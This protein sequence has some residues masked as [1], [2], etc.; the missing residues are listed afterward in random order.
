MENNTTAYSL[1]MAGGLLGCGLLAYAGARERPGASSGK[2]AALAVL[3]ILLGVLCA[4]VCAMAAIL[5]IRFQTA[6]AMGIGNFIAGLTLED[7]PF[8]GAVGG[9]TLG[10]YLAGKCMKLPGADTLNRFA[11]AG[12]FLIAMARFAE[13]FLGLFGTGELPEETVLP[14][15][16]A[17]AIDFSGDGSYVE[18]YLAVFMFEGIAAL[19]AMVFALRK[20]AAPDTFIRTLFYICLAQVFFESLRTTSIA[21][22]FVK[23]EQL[24]C[25]LYAEAVLVWYG[26]RG[27]GLKNRFLP[28]AAGLAVCAL[29]VAE[30]FALD[31]TDLPHWLI[32]ICMGLELV[33]LGVL[34][35]RAHQRLTAAK[36]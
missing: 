19:A 4:A 21:W 36:Q 28:A 6:A 13:G 24:A 26:E 20:K 9:F 5:L 35:H 10:V 1:M 17:V 12:A 29:I 32:Y 33:L 8:F 23:V 7:L 11:A 30:E 3:E 14:F 31:K 16:L 15:P 34:E 18:Y 27:K 2:A 22:L 25:F